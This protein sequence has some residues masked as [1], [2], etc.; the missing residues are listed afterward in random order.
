MSNKCQRTFDNRGSKKSIH[1]EQ[2]V[3]NEIDDR[4]VGM[5]LASIASTHNAEK[6]KTMRS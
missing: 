3:L 2:L 1:T 6:H 5:L 4:R